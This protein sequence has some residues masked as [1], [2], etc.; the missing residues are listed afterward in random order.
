MGFPIYLWSQGIAFFLISPLISCHY[1]I[2]FT[3]IQWFQELRHLF[4]VISIVGIGQK[5]IFPRDCLNPS[6]QAFRTLYSRVLRFCSKLGSDLP[7]F[8][9]ELSDTIIPLECF[10]PQGDRLLDAGPIVVS[11]FMQGIITDTSV[12]SW[13]QEYLES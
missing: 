5:Q 13:Y 8:I 6:R 1:K 10:F 7:G 9:R 12:Y 11:S 2:R 3:C 4:Q